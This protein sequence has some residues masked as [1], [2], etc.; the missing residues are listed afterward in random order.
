MKKPEIIFESEDFI[1]IN[2]PAG[3]LSIPDRTQSAE[4]L[5]DILI[6]QYGQIFTIHRLDKETSG[7]IV[8]AKNE[9]AHKH[10]SKAFEERSVEKIYIGLVQGTMTQEEGS[11]DAGIMEHPAK[12]GTMISHKKGKSALTHYKV[13]ESLGPY[14][15]VEF[16][17]H[18]GRTHQIRVHMKEI[19]HSIVCD[20]IY[21]NAQPIFISSFKRKYKLSKSE[22]EERPI[23]NRLGLHAY[24]LK[25]ADANGNKYSF[26]A[27]L[28]KDMRALVSQLKKL[29]ER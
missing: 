11:V 9:V 2:K 7:L 20:P 5:K 4:S 14:S 3:V 27:E 29:A 13:M 22:E 12:N 28:P 10:F 8:F 6:K 17:I 19:G 16:Q 1:V 21:G 18:T 26:E 15:L 24:Q 25:L 23:L